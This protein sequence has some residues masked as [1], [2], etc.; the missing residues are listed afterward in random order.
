[1]DF[2]FKVV[3]GKPTFGIKPQELCDDGYLHFTVN[4]YAQ[5]IIYNTKLR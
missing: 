1:M 4:Y 2:K 3:K 5:I